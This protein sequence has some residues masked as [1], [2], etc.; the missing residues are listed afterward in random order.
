MPSRVDLRQWEKN[1]I[2]NYAGTWINLRKQ[3]MD[4]QIKREDETNERRT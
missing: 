4:I 3:T 1:F 2:K